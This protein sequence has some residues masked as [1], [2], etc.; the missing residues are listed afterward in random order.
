MTPRDKQSVV[1]CRRWC[2]ASQALTH[3]G[4]KLLLL[5]PQVGILSQLLDL[6]EVET[7]AVFG[8]SIVDTTS[9]IGRNVILLSKVLLLLNC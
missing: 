3:A 4:P 6:A 7:P 5:V 2:I 9:V 1:D 8:Q